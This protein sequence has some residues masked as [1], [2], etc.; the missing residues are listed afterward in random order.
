V[1][2]L[3]NALPDSDRENVRKAQRLA[4]RSYTL[5]QI[6]NRLSLRNSSRSNRY[7]LVMSPD[8]RHAEIAR[9]TLAPMAEARMT[10]RK[11]ISNLKRD[12]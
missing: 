4:T 3:R 5:R 9:E 10:A 12:I 6:P 7:L 2:L 1:P 11:L 8:P